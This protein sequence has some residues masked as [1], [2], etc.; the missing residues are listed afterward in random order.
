MM[1]SSV[2]SVCLVFRCSG[3]T[4]TDSRARNTHADPDFWKHGRQVLMLVNNS[5]TGGITMGYTMIYHW[6]KN[7][8]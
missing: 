4:M 6:S 2:N 5:S 1:I 3:A 7:I 8:S